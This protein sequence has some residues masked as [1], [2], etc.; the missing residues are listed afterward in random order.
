MS[1]ADH[2]LD[3]KGLKCPLPALKTA[4][5][6]KTLSAGATLRV[7]CTDPLSVIDIP[8]LLAETGDELV[9]KAQDG[10]VLCF[11]IRRR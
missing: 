4:K 8:N 11:V 10:G 9:S 5:F 2:V 6:L 1:A 7:D 3:L